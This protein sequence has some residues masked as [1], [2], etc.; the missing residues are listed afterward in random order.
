MIKKINLIFITQIY[1]FTYRLTCAGKPVEI[2]E[3]TLK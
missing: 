1:L 3:I 2:N